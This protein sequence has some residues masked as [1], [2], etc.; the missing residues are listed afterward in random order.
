MKG[1]GPLKA[2]V[3]VLDVIAI[4]LGLWTSHALW[5]WYRP[6]L[7]VVLEVTWLELLPSNPFM[8][9]GLVLLV[10]W[11][12]AMHEVG[13][14]D[15]RR[16]TNSPRVAAGVSRAALLVPLV[17]LI[18]QFLLPDRTY[19]RFL[20][21]AF[22]GFTGLF[23]LAFRLTF[24]QLQRYIPHPIAQQRVAIV[25]SGRDAQMMAQRI[26]RFGH[27]AY[28]LVGFI[29][30]THS[31]SDTIDVAADRLLGGIGSLTDVV[32]QHDIHLIVL[33]T[34]NINRDEALLLATQA[35][36]MGLQVMQA[37]FN[38]GLVASPRVNT[39]TLGDLQLIDLTSLT[40]PTLGEQ[41]KRLLD[42]SI[43]GVGFL[44]LLPFL[45][46]VGLVIKS[47]DGGP[48]LFLQQRSGRGGRQFSLLKFRSMVV[49]AEARRAQL[50]DLNEQDGVLFKIK[51]DPR[52]TPFGRF[53]RKFSVD[54]LPQI[55][56]V[57][58]G[59]MNLVGPRPLPMADLIGI[60]EEPELRYWFERRSKVRPGITGPWQVS[61]RSD[62][63][64]KD[65]M[66]YDIE[67]IQH[68]SLWLDIV[69]LI[70]TIPAVLRGRGA[71]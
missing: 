26:D 44:V 11:L 3:I 18:L 58:R 63:G 48:A 54:E 69:I 37:P 46:V 67:Y 56:N 70:K 16:M 20:I 40:Y 5:I 28:N 38:W 39:A 29:C 50:A 9:P 24:F 22:C 19:S 10:V 23:L 65:M 27:H 31:E 57:I 35:H 17:T 60:D 25:G 59:D 51:D 61:G 14:Y 7:E 42:L 66:Q 71:Q 30:P 49:D 45:G 68:W 12:L 2:I 43:A 62:L 36:Q 34:R 8:P 64:F 13:L 55:W 32:N 33:A 47:Q 21:L 41:M 15:P 6:H 53:I 52:I 4:L 1:T